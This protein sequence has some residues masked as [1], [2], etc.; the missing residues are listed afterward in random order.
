MLTRTLREVFEGKDYIYIPPPSADPGFISLHECVWSA[1][2]SLTSTSVLQKCY[3]EAF[4]LTPRQIMSLGRFFVHTLGIAAACEWDDIVFEIG[5]QSDR[6][7][8]T[9]PKARELYECLLNMGP[10]GDDAEE[11]K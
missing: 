4:S 1:P 7:E 5:C 10:A 2:V 11:L 8:M 6:G 9:Y 3:C